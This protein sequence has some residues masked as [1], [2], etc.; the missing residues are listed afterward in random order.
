M[1][2]FDYLVN[3]S[4]FSLLVSTPLIIRSFIKQTPLKKVQIWVGVYA[5]IV[6]I[7][8]ILLAVKQQGY[9]YDIRYAPVILVFAYLGPI[10]G[11]VTGILSLLTRLG[12]NGNW[13]PAIIGW[14]V[15]MFVFTILHIY[16]RRI[17]PLIRCVAFFGTYIVLYMCTVFTFHILLNQPLFHFQYLLFVMLGVIVGG[18]LIESNERLR[19]IVTERKYMERTLEESELKYRLI[20]ENTSD[21]IMVLDGDCTVSYFSPSHQYVLGYQAYELE[22]MGLRE[23]LHPEDEG[24]YMIAVE[25]MFESKESRSVTMEFRLKHKDGPWIEFESHCKPVKGEVNRIEHIVIISRDISERRKAEEILLQSEKLSFAGQLAAGVAHEIRNPLTTIKGFLSLYKKE[26]A[27]LKY[28]DLLL[29]ELER[30]EIITSELL[31]LAKPQAVQ[32]TRTDVKELLEYIVELLS[33]QAHMNNIQFIKVYGES[34]FPI[35]CEQTRLKQV[36]LNILKNAIESMPEGGLIQI[37]LHKEA[38]EECLVTIKDQGCGIPEELLAKLG[39]PFYSLKE[40]GTGLGLMISHR[41]IEQHNGSIN[42]QSKVNEGTLIEIRL[43]LAE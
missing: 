39:Q 22:H 16:L 7:I 12:S 34:C 14:A 18:L 33:P 32:L 3:L 23:L 43:P 9:S 42:Y 36:F 28:S 29:S 2:L 15:I 20:A 17:A 21:L 37:S 38:E 11:I 27:S 19:R 13:L 41:I 8:L 25:R 35:T 10:P 5:G 40:K 31:S 24:I 30:I 1:I 6:S 4:I 26:H